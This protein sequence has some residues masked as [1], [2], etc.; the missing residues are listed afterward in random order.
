MDDPAAAIFMDEDD[1][2]TY[3]IKAIDDAR[4]L[5]KT[6]Y[7]RPADNILTQSQL[8]QKW[9]KLTGKKLDK[10]SIS[11]QDFLASMQGTK[12]INMNNLV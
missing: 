10:I 2:A 12:L 8:I 11:A 1:V 5:N 3:A 9:E 6:L 4:T 7:I